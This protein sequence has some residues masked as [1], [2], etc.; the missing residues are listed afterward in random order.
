MAKYT[1]SYCLPVSV[2]EVS[3]VMKKILES[4]QLTVDF[5]NKDYIMAKDNDKKVSFSNLVKVDVIIDKPKSNEEQTTLEI[6]TNNGQ[7]NIQ[8]NNFAWQK[9]EEIQ[10]RINN[11]FAIAALSC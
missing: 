10:K 6:T 8:K 4:C 3:S 11:I 9:F 5:E 2:Q 1:R 7:L